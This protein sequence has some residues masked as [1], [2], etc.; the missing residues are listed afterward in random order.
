MRGKHSKSRRMVEEEEV[1]RAFRNDN[2]AYE[3]KQGNTKK[4]K[5]NGL[6]I[7]GKVIL[8]LIII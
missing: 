3:N 5:N 6:R 4:K 7:L 2:K 8:V 1:P